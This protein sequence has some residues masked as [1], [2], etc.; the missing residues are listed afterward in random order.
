MEF[1]TNTK[2]NTIGGV[3]YLLGIFL[4]EMLFRPPSW[5]YIPR[6]LLWTAL[7]CFPISYV[8][9]I[10]PAIKR[11][12]G[13]DKINN[14]YLM[15][16]GQ[17]IF[18]DL[19]KCDITENSSKTESTFSYKHSLDNRTE[20]FNSLPMPYDNIS[21]LLKLSDKKETIIYVDNKDR[22]KYFFDL[23]FITG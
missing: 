8:M 17:K 10:E 19:S 5:D 23:D 12:K 4:V 15:T 16:Y 6:W 2:R 9:L 21:L 20:I 14:M 18:V 1:N 3:I 7:L 13:R 22:S 11:K